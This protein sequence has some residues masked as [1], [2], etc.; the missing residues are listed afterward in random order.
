MY[1]RTDLVQEKYQENDYSDIEK[2]T[3]GLKNKAWANGK[4]KKP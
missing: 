1:M 4:T 2:L 3:T